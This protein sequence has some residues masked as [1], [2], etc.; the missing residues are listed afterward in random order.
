[1]N[2]RLSHLAIACLSLLVVYSFCWPTR[3][4]CQTLQ[5]K[6]NQMVEISLSSPRQYAHPLM[7]VFVECLLIGPSGESFSVG[8][9]WDG[10]NIY[11]VRFALPTPGTWTFTTLCTDTSNLGLHNISGSVSVEKSNESQPFSSK[12]F[13]KVSPNGRYLTYDNGEPFF[14]L[15][16]TAWEITW[17]SREPDMLSYIA[18]RQKKGFTALQ[19]VVMSHQ[20][21]YE[22][23]VRN[24]SGEDFFLNNDRTRL[25]PRYFDYLDRIVQAAN[26]AGMVVA[27]VPLWA[28]MMEYYTRGAL[29]VEQAMLLARYV[30]ARYAGSN[31]LW[32]VGGDNSYETVERIVFWSQFAL[33][34]KKTSGVHHLVT[35]HPKAWTSSS[36][37]FNKNDT[38]L[39]F[40]MYQSSH[41][42]GGDFTWRAGLAG[43]YSNNHKPLLD[44]EATY[45]DIYSNL[46]LPGD[47]TRMQSFRVQSVDVRQSSYESIFSGALVGITYGANGIWQ[48]DTPELP[49]THMPRVPATQAQDFPG[50]VHMMILKQIMQKIPWYDAV[51]A[52]NLVSDFRSQENYIPIITTENRIVAYLPHHTE[53]VQLKMFPN[54]RSTEYFWINP[55]TGDT[56][57]TQFVGAIPRF[58]PPTSE[59]WIL[60]IKNPEF[61]AQIDSRTD[62]TR[63]LEQNYPNPFN[64][65]TVIRYHVPKDMRVRISVYNTLG[66]E[67]ATLVD[68][69]HTPGSYIVDFDGSRLSGGVY[70]C[71]INSRSFSETRKFILVK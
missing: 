48:W 60:V 16:D 51:P 32:I 58:V 54:S 25:N 47:T 13:L 41:V 44:G 23:G 35:V 21:F 20:F 62:G 71:R 66:Q 59:D 39:D 12:G 5:A 4:A 2:H 67:V 7:D 50:S 52:Q 17:K 3:L 28:G 38:W 55:S 70:F 46:W 49:G 1:M 10:G 36:E 9:F 33:A 29:T 27:L 43:Y 37:Y 40:D 45:E 42:A 15:G 30:G 61:A 57:V 19:V 31:I 26:D 18:D 22:Y 8:G 63:F 53:W 24:R 6:T 14:Y 68:Q 56:S 11:R 34:L 69:E 64:P 65:T